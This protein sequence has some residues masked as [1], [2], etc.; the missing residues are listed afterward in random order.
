M[1]IAVHISSQTVPAHLLMSAKQ[2]INVCK[3]NEACSAANAP[4]PGGFAGF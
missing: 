3:A 4:V 2:F 1:S